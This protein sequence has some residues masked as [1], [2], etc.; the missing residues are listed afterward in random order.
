MNCHSAFWFA[1]LLTISSGALADMPTIQTP[2]PLIHLADNLDEADKLG[3]CIDT[4]GRGFGEYLHAH[5]C[6]PQGGDVQF[7]FAADP[8]LIRSVAF[9]EYC[10]KYDPGQTS[11]MGLVTCDPG[12][13]SQAFEHN[14]AGEITLAS[15]PSLCLAVGSASASAGPYLSRSLDMRPCEDVPIERKVWIVLP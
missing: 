3:W 7:S 4:Q 14:E 11:P 5:S 10:M 9:T 12:D 2:T 6:K 8:G 15:D 13:H 1:S